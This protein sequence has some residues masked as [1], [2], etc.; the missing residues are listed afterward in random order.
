MHNAAA[1]APTEERLLESPAS[2]LG[3]SFLAWQGEASV[4]AGPGCIYRTQD[5]N[6]R[7]LMKAKI[8]FNESQVLLT[9]PPV[10]KVSPLHNALTGGYPAMVL[11]DPWHLVSDSVE[12]K[13][14]IPFT[15]WRHF[16]R[17]VKHTFDYFSGVASEGGEVD[18]LVFEIA[19]VGYI[20]VRDIPHQA[21][22]GRDVGRFVMTDTRM[23]VS[24]PGYKRLSDGTSLGAVGGPWKVKALFRDGF[25]GYGCAEVTAVH[26]QFETD[27]ANSASFLHCADIGVDTGQVG[28]FDGVHYPSEPKQFEYEDGTFYMAC[29]DATNCRADSHTNA[30][31]YPMGQVFEDIGFVTRTFDGDGTYPLS[32]VTEPELGKVVAARVTFKDRMSKMFD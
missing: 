10:A 8:E 28:F 13:L 7:I 2:Q 19:G 5:N 11:D 32:V 16:L 18:K 29:C 25:N 30:N 12:T 27:A 31:L 1:G 24:D 6:T 3:G 22:F 4:S 21:E 17:G 14:E 26:E 23:H 20:E 15:A 9:I